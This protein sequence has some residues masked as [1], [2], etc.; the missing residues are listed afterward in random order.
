MKRLQETELAARREADKAKEAIQ[1]AEKAAKKLSP[2]EYLEEAAD[3]MDLQ[4]M[5]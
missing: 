2:E 3:E 4:Q 5:Q 1:E